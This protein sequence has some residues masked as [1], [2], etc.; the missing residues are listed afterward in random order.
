MSMISRAVCGAGRVSSA[1]AVC[2]E[3]I[4][5]VVRREQNHL[6]VGMEVVPKEYHPS[7]PGL[8]IDFKV[9]A[10][11]NNQPATAALLQLQLTAHGSGVMHAA[12]KTA[13]A[14]P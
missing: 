7:R 8:S 11:A 14:V 12:R 2:V 4:K 13:V 6:R 10:L 5:P 3:A 1:L 9:G